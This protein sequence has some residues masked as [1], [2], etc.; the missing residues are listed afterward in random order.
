VRIS[1]LGFVNWFKDARRSKKRQFAIGVA[2]LIL[3]PFLGTTLAASVSINSGKSQEFGQGS[4]ATI[5]C[6]STIGT[7]IGEVWNQA[8]LY[9]RVDT[10]TISTLNN[11]N[12]TSSPT[13]DGGCGGKHLKFQLLD[14]NG[15]ALAIGSG[16]TTNV[17]INIPSSDT[18]TITD[19]SGGTVLNGD[20][21]SLAGTL[22]NPTDSNGNPQSTLSIVL[23]VSNLVNAGSVYRVTIESTD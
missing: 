1:D 19:G 2:L 11:K 12:V 20:T 17:I 3:I 21:A 5:A 23:P 18:S 15:N 16:G 8:T 22:T 14:T 9:F 13:Q 6:D 10:I 7:S 4:Q